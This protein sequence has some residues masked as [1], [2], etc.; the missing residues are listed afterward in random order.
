M[1]ISFQYGDGEA[2][3]VNLT[4]TKAKEELLAFLNR[5]SDSGKKQW[6]AKMKKR[7]ITYPFTEK[8]YDFIAKD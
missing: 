3:S 6:M 1:N 2:E 7:D 5:F 8:H 4:E